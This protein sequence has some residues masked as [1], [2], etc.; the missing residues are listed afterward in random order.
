[1]HELKLDRVYKRRRIAHPILQVQFFNIGKA[2]DDIL[3]I[4]A[5][6]PLVRDMP[7][8]ATVR[9]ADQKLATAIDSEAFHQLIVLGTIAA[10]LLIFLVVRKMTGL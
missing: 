4:F 9:S 8:L 3:N 1:M 6:S 2:T 7:S 10:S 5:P